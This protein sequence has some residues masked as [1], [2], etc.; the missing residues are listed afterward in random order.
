M[1]FPKIYV[2]AYYVKQPLDIK[3]TRFAGY[4]KD[5]SNVSYQEQLVVANKIKDRDYQSAGI[6]L[7]AVNKKILKGSWRPTATFDELWDYFSKNYE[8][9]MKPLNELL[10]P[11]VVP[12]PVP[13]GT[14]TADASRVTTSPVSSTISS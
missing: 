12:G 14:D 1:K 8:N 9:Y 10:N 5:E 2:I 13:V 3:Q 4:M 11:T 6:I 7:D